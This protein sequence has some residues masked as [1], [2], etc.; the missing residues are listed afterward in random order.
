MDVVKSRACWC[1]MVSRMFLCYVVLFCFCIEVHCWC[2]VVN[3]VIMG[4]IVVY[5]FVLWCVVV[6]Q[7]V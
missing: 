4:M 3:C 5:W 7:S 1:I 6:Y 2:I